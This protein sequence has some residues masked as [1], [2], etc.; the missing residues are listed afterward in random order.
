LIDTTL[1]YVHVYSEGVRKYVGLK[2]EQV[3]EGAK[4]VEEKVRNGSAQDGDHND[5]HE[6]TN[7]DHVSSAGSD[8]E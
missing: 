8:S 1:D 3:E 4:E 6:K 7:G 5:I 2:A